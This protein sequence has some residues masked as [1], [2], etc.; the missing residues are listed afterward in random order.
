MLL[1]QLGVGGE[2]GEVVYLCPADEVFEPFAHLLSVPALD[3]A[4]IDAEGGVGD[5]EAFV[6]ADNL[7]VALA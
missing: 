6:D 4:V 2:D 3:A 1:R 5:D 7:A